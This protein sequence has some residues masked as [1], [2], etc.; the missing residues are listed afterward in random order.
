MGGQWVGPTQDAVLELIKE[1]GLETFPSYDDGEALTVFDGKSSGTPT[2]P[3]ASR[4]RARWRSAGCGSEIEI[5]R[6]HRSPRA[7]LGDRRGARARP[8]DP[9]RLAGRQHRRH[10][11]PC[12]SCACSSRR[13]SPPRPRDVAAALPVLRQV[14]HGLETLVATTG[15]AQESRVVGGTHQIS[16]R[17]AEELGDRV[18]LNAVVPDD[19]PRRRRR[20]GRVRGRL[21]DG[22]ARHRRAAADAGRP[23]PL[24]PRAAR[25]CATGSPSRCRQGPS[26][27]SR[28]AT[29][30]RSGARTGSAASCSASTTS[31]TSCSTTPRTTPPAACWSASSRARTPAPPSR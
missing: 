5:P 7:R 2:R 25:R 10:A 26:S 3:S 21:G 18:R 23:V 30:R 20:P 8:A 13:S 31:S 4:W 15:G 17:M 29:R 27:S 24:R 9:G 6:C 11:S 14:R 19:P 28:S 1:L 22:R 16:E 12:A